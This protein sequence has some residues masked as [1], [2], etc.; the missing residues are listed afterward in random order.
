MLF[1]DHASQSWRLPVSSTEYNYLDKDDLIR[2]RVEEELFKEATPAPPKVQ[3]AGEIERIEENKEP[4][5]SLIVYS[6]F[7]SG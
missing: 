6:I 7:H 5:Y 4:I 2:F 1:S 3:S